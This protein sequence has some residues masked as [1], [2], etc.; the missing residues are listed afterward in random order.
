MLCDWAEVV[1]GK[2]YLQGA[3]WAQVLANEPAQI[4]VALLIRVPYDQTNTQHHVSVRLLTEDGQ[5]YP[6]DQPAEFEFDFEMGRP[7]GM[8]KGQEQVLPFAAKVAGLPFAR[9]G[10]RWELL[11]DGEPADDMS[12]VAITQ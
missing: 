11:V 6:E 5:L 8:K 9:G 12:F 4:A 3:G 7:P 1:Q 10:Y 2:L